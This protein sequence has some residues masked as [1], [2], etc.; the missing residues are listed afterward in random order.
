MKKG[1]FHIYVSSFN[2]QFKTTCY[3]N[4]HQQRYIIKQSPTHDQHFRL[5][6]KIRFKAR[7]RQSFITHFILYDHDKLISEFYFPVDVLPH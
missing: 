2:I 4:N 6:N 3:A 1:K 7:R 5:N